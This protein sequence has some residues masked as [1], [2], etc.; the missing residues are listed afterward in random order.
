MK[1][2]DFEKKR[3][4]N[5]FVSSFIDL[6]ELENRPEDKKLSFYINNGIRLLSMKELPFVIF[7]DSKTKI[8]LEDEKK[9]HELNPNVVIIETSSEELQVYNF[10][11]KNDTYVPD[12]NNPSKD[13]FSYMA[14]IINK[15][16]YVKT[17][18]EM[19]PFLS[20]RFTWIDFGIMHIIKENEVDCFEK[21][22]EFIEI[23]DKEEE[24]END[25]KKNQIRI[26]GCYLPNTPIE[27][28]KLRELAEN[29]KWVFCGGLFSGK[30]D[31]LL[32]FDEEVKKCLE[33]LKSEK[34]IT[35]EVNIWFYVYCKNPLLFDFYLADHNISM[36]KNFKR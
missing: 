21:T 11:N 25:E 32:E 10:L 26:P 29:P 4:K 8:T 13:T 30:I 7:V 19:N 31:P 20:E 14:A 2:E 18:I 17:A 6:N 9:I 3:F 27:I 36:I 28:L 33:I 12:K 16:H 23:F 1:R 24:E 22:L 34:F 5:T 15:T 35:W